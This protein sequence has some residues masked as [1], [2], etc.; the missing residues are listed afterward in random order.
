MKS[1]YKNVLILIAIMFF[2]N[3][4]TS[5]LNMTGKKTID[6]ETGVKRFAEK[7]VGKYYY[8]TQ[9]HIKRKK[10]DLEQAVLFMKKAVEIDT[11]SIYL[12]KELAALYHLKK[13]GKRALEVVNRILETNPDDIQ[14]LMILGRIKQSMNQ[15][16]EAA[17]AYEK[18]ITLD[19][20]RRNAFLLLGNIYMTQEKWADAE[21]VYKLL[22]KQFPESYA[23]F[24][25][26][27][28]LNLAQGRAEK[29]KKH[30][31]KSLDLEP[32]LE[33]SRFEIAGIYESENNPKK[34][35]ESYNKILKA[36][37]TSIKAGLAAGYLYHKLGMDKDSDTVLA[38]LAQRSVSEPEVIRIIVRDYIDKKDYAKGIVIIDKMIGL[39]SESSD[40]QYL[41]GAAN[42]GMGNKKAAISH[43]EKVQPQ[44]R[45]F[46]NAAVHASLLYQ[47]RGEIDRA[48][49]FMEDVISRAGDFPDF[50]LYLGSFYEQKDDFAKAE[51]VLLN[52]LKIDKDHSRLHFRLGVVYDKMEKKDASVEQMKQVIKL[53]P[54]NASA[55]NYLGYTYADMGENLKEAERLILE[56][57]KYKPD[58]GYITDS[59]GWVYYKMGLYEKA[60]PLLEKAAQLVSDDPT[61]LEHLGDL[62]V[63]MKSFEKAVEYYQLSIDQ[64]SKEKEKI[65]RKIKAIQH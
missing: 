58:D 41:A 22:I 56:A 28:K 42:D 57:L 47:E 59:L 25:Y 55:L 50:Y 14:T 64:G 49:A 61:V 21:R 37:N 8:F 31:L 15:A 48:I 11:A 29:A 60:L 1:V 53:D 63:K 12:K 36:N 17:K 38:T 16:D 4:C 7:K 46:K 10:G 54:K 32:K 44:T 20:N 33:A 65:K 19:P 2:V 23:G 13:D 51:S 24:F 5:L 43:F 18:L 40:L 26:L 9:S 30:F 52:G 62:H 45:F 3:G 6:K 39:V 35:L 27:G 34:A